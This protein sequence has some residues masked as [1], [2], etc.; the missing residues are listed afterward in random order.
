M[1]LFFKLMPSLCG[2][3]CY[4]LPEAESDYLQLTFR[5]A[6][7]SDATKR[8]QDFAKEKN[9]KI[10]GLEQVD[11]IAYT[12]NGAPI[13]NVYTLSSPITLIFQVPEALVN[14][15]YE[16]A[17]ISQCGDS[18]SLIKD[19]DDDPYTVTFAVDKLEH[20]ALVYAPSIK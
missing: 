17:V 2:I 18:I 15:N 10:A 8:I 7:A 14:S 5:G 19:Q 4:L 20:L 12:K 16:Y 6:I 13:K 1:L 3:L 9:A 11:A